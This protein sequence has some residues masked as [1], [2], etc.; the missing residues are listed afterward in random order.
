MM[1]VLIHLIR[2]K[3]DD[4]ILAIRRSHEFGVQW[5]YWILGAECHRDCRRLGAA[6]VMRQF[7]VVLDQL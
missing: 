7:L 5:N 2:Q 4:R 6:A 1:C 3:V